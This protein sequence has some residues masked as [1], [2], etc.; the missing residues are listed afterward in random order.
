[1]SYWKADGSQSVVS[2]LVALAI[3]CPASRAQ[4]QSAAAAPSTGGEIG[5]LEEITVTARKREESL[6]NVPV[7][8]QAIPAARLELLQVTELTD[9]PKIVPGLNFGRSVLSVG[10][11]VSIR[12]IGTASQDPGV[13]QSVALNLD[14]LAI[15]NGLAFNSGMFDIGEVEVLKGPQ[16]LFFGK[17]SPGGVISLRSADPTDKVEVIGSA[18]YEFES[19][20]PRASL[21]LSGPVTDTLKLRLA[22]QYYHQEGYFRNEAIAAP[23]TGAETPDPDRAP[24]GTDF[25][26]RGTALWDPS[27]VFSARLKVDMAYDRSIEAEA[28]EV[29]GCAGGTAPLPGFPDFLGGGNTCSLGRDQHIVYLN[30]ADFPGIQG[31]GVPYL[32]T[33]QRYGTLELNYHPSSAIDVSS[34][35]GYYHLTSSSMLNGSESHYAGPFIAVNNRFKRHDFTEELRATSDFKGPVNFTVGGLYE[36]GFFSDRVAVLGNQAYGFLAPTLEDGTTPVDVKTWSAY[37]QLRWTIVRQLELDAGLRY[38]DEKRSEQPFNNLTG[39]PTAVTTPAIHSTNSSP[40]VTLTY[41]PIDEVTLYVAYKQGFKSGSF[42][43]GTPPNSGADNA[44]GPEKVRGQELGFK[45]RLLDNQLAVNAAY[46]YYKYTGL[47]VGVEAPPVGGV[48]VVQTLNAATAEVYGVDLDSTFHPSTIQGLQLNGD[49][50]WNHG[51][52]THFTNGPC[53]AGQ[54]IALGCNEQLNTFTGAYTSQNLSGTPL[55]RAPA[56]Q[57]NLG[58]D[59]TIPVV[60]NYELTLSN[61]YEYSSNYLNQ[62]AVGYPG[63]YQFQSAYVMVDAGVTLRSPSK[64]WEFALVGK[65]LSDKVISGNCEIGNS[66]SGSTLPGTTG[67][68]TSAPYGYGDNPC[69]AEPGREVWLRVTWRPL[70]SRS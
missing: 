44:F 7:D 6:L 28:S 52:Y 63:N 55:V 27:S 3:L 19:V 18:G 25:N 14:G 62:L 70:A 47:Q 5:Q 15:G 57:M 12:G 10:T 35:T 33:D 50:E 39:E 20:Q 40:E 24:W 30:A 16:A 54:T 59:Y 67:T 8:E 29:S 61:A 45:S 37:G 58:V 46:Y 41:K 23:G 34:T 43:I 17:E 21:I 38:S 66:K 64:M 53:W 26:V 11:L 36:D 56:W 1:M 2:C 65:N 31:D 49:V 42:S 60:S 9:L 13:D 69:F 32:M 68:T 4:A 48:P 22:G 51:R